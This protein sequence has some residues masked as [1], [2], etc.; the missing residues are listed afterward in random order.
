M[1]LGLCGKVALVAG[2]SHGIGR[3]V[4]RTLSAEG[5]VIAANARG[6]DGL[7][8]LSGEL[9]AGASLHPAD[10]TKA[11]CCRALIADVLAAHGRLDILICNVGSGRSAPPGQEDEDEWRRVFDVNFHSATHLIATARPALEP[12]TAIVC[13]S[14]ICGFESLGAPLTYSAAKAALNSYI[15]GM[16]RPLAAAGVRLNAVAPGNVLVEEG[17]WAERKRKDPGGLAD[18]LKREVPM[19][20]LG[21]PA[22]IADVVAFLASP[23]AAFVTGAVWVADGGQT[24]S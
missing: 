5:C 22:E 4:A 3:A 11:A 2:A 23:R 21:T 15:H 10:V 19:A 20:R 13:I 14:S 9:P 17:H 1:D 8:R 24:R 16:A 6:E 7:G 12:G 18:Y